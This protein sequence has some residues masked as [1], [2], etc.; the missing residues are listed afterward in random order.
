MQ[1]RK[2]IHEKKTR[3]L[4]VNYWMWSV[5][6][7]K[8]SHGIREQTDSPIKTDD[9]TIEIALNIGGETRKQDESL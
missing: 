2:K 9:P 5:F 8:D 6:K 3:R 4:F 1:D 7:T